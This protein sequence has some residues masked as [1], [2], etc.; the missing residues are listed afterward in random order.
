MIL[1]VY[2]REDRK[3]ESTVQR[4]LSYFEALPPMGQA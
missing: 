3:G 1:Y 2:E 4:I